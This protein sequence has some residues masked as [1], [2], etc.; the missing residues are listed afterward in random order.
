MFLGS[1]P[2]QRIWPIGRYLWYLFWC[3]L[4]ALGLVLAHWQYQRAADKRQLQSHA[5]IWRPDQAAQS[6]PSS[7]QA[8][9]IQGHWL[10]QHSYWLDNRQYQGA[11][12]VAL[13]TPLI[14]TQGEVFLVDRGF[15]ATGGHRQSLAL[16]AEGPSELVTVRGIWQSWQ[17]KQPLVLG[18]LQEGNRLQALLAQDWQQRLH[19]LELAYLG[20]L[21]QHNGTRPAWWQPLA[22][23]PERHLGY[24][25]QWLLL[26]LLAAL[27]A[28]MAD[29]WRKAKCGDQE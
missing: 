4:L 8:I 1:S 14:N 5:D 23:P 26:A 12:G 29:P 27:M 2:A 21:H 18:Q 15:E 3:S 24:A 19:P 13:I 25:M 20:V 16:P 7:G 10:L 11:V 22:M 28:L 6:Q 9:E 17:S